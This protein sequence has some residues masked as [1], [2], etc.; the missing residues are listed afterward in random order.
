M[1]R[2]QNPA[3]NSLRPEVPAPIVDAI[4]WAQL[5][6]IHS[7]EG[8]AATRGNPTDGCVAKC[9][10]STAQSW[11]EKKRSEKIYANTVVLRYPRKSIKHFMGKKTQS[12]RFTCKP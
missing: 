7:E 12:Q 9:T 1:L 8:Y 4:A 3:L 11:L 5:T 2:F 6:D 10:E